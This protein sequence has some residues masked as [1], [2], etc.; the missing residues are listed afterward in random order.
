MTDATVTVVETRPTPGT[1]RPYD[2]PEVERSRLANGLSLIVANLP[3]RPLV[4]GTLVLRNGA[5]DEPDGDAGA[6]VLAARALTEG[7]ERY[8]AIELVEAGERLG[9][10][11]H[12]DAGW[13]A[14][15]IGV[16]VP[17]TRLEAALEL[18]AEVALHP[19]FPA[20]EV[21]RLRDERL[22]DLLQAEADPRRRADEAYSATIYTAGSP[23]RRPSGGTKES[24]ERLD[25]ALLRA[26]Y[27]RGLD[28]ARATLIIGGDLA[29]IDVPAIAQRLFGAW[30]SP[31]GAGPTGLVVAEGA[32]RERFIRVLHRPGSVQTEI[33]IGHIGLPRRIPDFH[34]LSVMG[35]IL[36]GLF[37]SRLNTKLREEKGYTYGAGAG[38]DLRRAA[39]PF[40]ARAA[41]NT[42]VTVP[43]IVDILAE[44]DRIRD[45]PVTDAELK[46]ARDFL[47]GVFPL[48]FETP[49]PVVGALAGLVIHE[50]PDDELARY[51]PAIEAVTVDAVQAAAR[52]HVHPD[53]AAIV[54]VGDAD[55][56]GAE[57]EAAGFGR[58]TIERETGVQDEGR[59][60]GVQEALGPVDEGPG[61]PTEGGE[62]PP[63]PAAG[64]RPDAAEPR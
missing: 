1:P 21:D 61:G 33:R 38:F 44:L 7:T 19:T 11:I 6:T 24:V 4:S 25:P 27:Q 10:A 54:L 56:F 43:A 41:V 3:G 51:R 20:A 60:E 49:G 57:L 62:D 15:S 28:P 53:A 31:F 26:A 63:A 34:A 14:M 16:D 58:V 37:N 22:N 18:L 17:A 52:A 9:A 30:G 42:E 36:G 12:A 55:A 45:E 48:R 64:D 35:A 46:A 23:Y 50:L 29:G 39:G 32:V 40:A 8:D 13:D 47:V 59:D 5:A 2:F